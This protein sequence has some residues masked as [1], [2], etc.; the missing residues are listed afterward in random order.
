MIIQAH[1]TGLG[2]VNTRHSG[3][4]LVETFAK[5]QEFIKHD[6]AWMPGERNLRIEVHNDFIYLTDRGH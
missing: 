1:C 3:E 2:W 6:P 4:T 5:A